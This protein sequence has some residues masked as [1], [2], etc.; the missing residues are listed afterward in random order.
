MVLTSVQI[1]V[2]LILLFCTQ[3]SAMLHQDTAAYMA[4]CR[5][6]HRALRDLLMGWQSD[7]APS[8]GQ[9]GVVVLNVPAW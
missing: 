9:G 1:L 6:H 2:T 5:Y 8:L 3:C 4:V 7:S